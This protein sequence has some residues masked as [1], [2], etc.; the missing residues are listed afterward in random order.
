MTKEVEMVIENLP[1]KTR[2]QAQVVF[3]GDFYQEVPPYKNC[4][5][6]KKEREKERKQKT[7]K[8]TRIGLTEE[9]SSATSEAKR[10]QRGMPS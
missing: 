3:T 6:I 1:T 9:F 5:H 4:S 8:G 10:Q 2:H 7:Y